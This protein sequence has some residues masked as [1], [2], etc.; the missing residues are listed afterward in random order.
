ME[1]NN[2]KKL[3]SYRSFRGQIIGILNCMPGM[4]ACMQTKDIRKFQNQKN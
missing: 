4:F 3:L 2:L 1:S